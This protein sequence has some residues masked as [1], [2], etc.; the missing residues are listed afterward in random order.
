MSAVVSTG[1]GN[2]RNCTQ[3]GIDCTMGCLRR[4]CSDCGGSIGGGG[5][6]VDD[7]DER[8]SG[9]PPNDAPLGEGATT[10][11]R[12]RMRSRNRPSPAPREAMAVDKR[13]SD[14]AER[15]HRLGDAD[16]AGDVGADRRSCRAL[17]YSSAVAAAARRGSPSMIS[18]SALLGVLEGPGVAAGVLLHLQRGGGDAAGVGRLAR[19]EGDAGLAEDARPPRAWTACWPPRPTAM[20]AVA[21]RACAASWRRQLVLGG[22]RHRHLGTGRPRCCRPGRSGRRGA[23]IARSRRC[24]RA[25]PP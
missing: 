14:H 22:A 11:D 17:P 23:P 7:G 1:P 12:T 2:T 4:S 19:A 6:E 20:T 13:E 5:R 16:E 18:A 8:G 25:R 10:C 15:D 24:G 21:R 3:P 9:H